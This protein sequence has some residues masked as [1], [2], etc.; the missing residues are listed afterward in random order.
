MPILQGATSQQTSTYLEKHVTGRVLGITL[1]TALVAAAI[2]TSIFTY[3]A[4]ALICGIVLGGAVLTTGLITALLGRMRS[5]AND[6]LEKKGAGIVPSEQS[7]RSELGKGDQPA[8]EFQPMA[9]KNPQSSSTTPHSTDAVP[10]KKK[11][12]EQKNDLFYNCFGVVNDAL[13]RIDEDSDW[14]DLNT[15]ATAASQGQL[16]TVKTLLAK[17]GDRSDP[18]KYYIAVAIAAR[19]GRWEIV[20]AMIFEESKN[21]RMSQI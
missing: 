14:T 19:Y 5:H 9:P 1:T 4:T 6:Q 18:T 8:Y 13:K 20:N 21:P 15:L 2:F 3:G 7:S 10:I 12:P 11:P 17:K 16:E